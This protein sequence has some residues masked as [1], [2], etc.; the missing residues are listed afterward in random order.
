[1]LLWMQKKSKKKCWGI[2]QKLRGERTSATHWK[3]RLLKILQ[4]QKEKV[5]HWRVLFHFIWMTELIRCQQ[6]DVALLTIITTCNNNPANIYLFKVNS[7]NNRKRWKICSQQATKTTERRHW[8]R[9]GAFI[10]NFKHISHLFLQFLLLNLNKQMLAWKLA[11]LINFLLMIYYFPYD[12]LFFLWY[13]IFLLE[14][15]QFRSD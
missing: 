2:E 6:S 4:R 15:R 1:M 13:A 3:M 10:V 9:S 12:I 14:P 5:E 7:G 8:R 11:K